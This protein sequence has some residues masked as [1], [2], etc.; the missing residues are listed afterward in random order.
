MDTPRA[1]RVD[2]GRIAGAAFLLLSGTF[3]LGTMLA[4]S[5]APGYDFH[6]A[7][8]SDLGV[9]DE[10]AVLFNGLLVAIGA[11]DL[12]GG[13]AL[14]RAL[15]RRWLAVPFVIAGVGAIGAG[16]VPLDRGGLHSIFALV[17]FLAVNVQV[18]AA[19]AL[20]AGPMRI[21]GVLAGAVGLIYV[22]VMIIGD[23]GTPEIFGAIGHGGAER[24]IA[25]PAM[26]WLL[27]FGGYLLAGREVTS[28]R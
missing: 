8:I 13:L 27:A 11:L 7:A 14:A 17:A 9:V 16:L 10:T 24:M 25:Y 26:L 12:V 3:L 22:V 2:D 23:A 18:I 1:D 21:L 20:L 15:G 4:A 5:I 28:R 19:A 6:G